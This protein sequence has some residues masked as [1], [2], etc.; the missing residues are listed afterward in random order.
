M[1]GHGHPQNNTSPRHSAPG[2]ARSGRPL[3]PGIGLTFGL[4]GD[5]AAG[6]R[7]HVNRDPI[8]HED[9]RHLG[10]LA[11]SCEASDSKLQENPA[12]CCGVLV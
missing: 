8:P 9:D 4:Y 11:P 1:C 6:R 7:G 12:M 10:R 2:S 5:P 3:S